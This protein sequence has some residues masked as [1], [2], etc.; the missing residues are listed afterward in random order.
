MVNKKFRERI[1]EFYK[2]NGRISYIKIKN[3]MA[4]ITIVN[5]Y[6]PTEE[7][8]DEEKNKFYEDLETLCEKIPKH[9]TLLIVGDI[10]AKIGKEEYLR[11]VAG[12][13]TVHEITNDNGNR[14]CNLA[15]GMNM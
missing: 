9:D 2:I 10:N 7:A 3:N 8:E 14:I 12:K 5:V 11:N 1:I 6:A 4:N 15:T 13:E